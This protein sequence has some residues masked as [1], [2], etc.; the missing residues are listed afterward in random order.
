ML[1]RAM[2]LV[3]TIPVILR[4]GYQLAC[5]MIDNVSDDTGVRMKY[6]DVFQ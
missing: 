6:L 3:E 1:A 5:H 2:A 4:A